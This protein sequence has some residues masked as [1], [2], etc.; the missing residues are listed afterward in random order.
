MASQPIRCL[1]TI[2][3]FKKKKLVIIII[4]IILII[5]IIIIIRYCAFLQVAEHVQRYLAQPI[6]Q[7]RHKGHVL[8]KV[9]KL[10][11]PVC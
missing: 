2:N 1:G 4:I 10:F 11:T 7:V 5:L 8:L 3:T 6:I 9:L